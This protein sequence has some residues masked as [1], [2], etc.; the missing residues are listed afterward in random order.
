MTHTIRG[1]SVG[2]KNTKVNVADN[3]ET[4]FGYTLSIINGKWKLLII[5]NLSKN[6]PVRYNELQRMMGKITYKTLS[7]TLKDMVADGI[8]HREEYPQI[9]PKVEYSLTEK[10]Q[11]LWPIIQTM[12]Q[13]G[14]HNKEI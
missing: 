14:D 11:T 2:M 3:E 7:S 9:P 1:D 13:W 5:Y 6:G 12:C 10:G 4:S 8:V